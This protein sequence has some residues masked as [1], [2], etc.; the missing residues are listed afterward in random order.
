M[1]YDLL[2]ILH[3]FSAALLLTSLVY[4]FWLWRKAQDS[5]LVIGVIQKQTWA[6]ILPAAIF[7]LATGFTIIS[8]KHYELSA[9]WIRGSVLGFIIVMGSWIGFIY[10]LFARQEV[11]NKKF[12]DLLQKLL[13]FTC[14]IALLSMIFL[15]ANK[16]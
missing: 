12:Y 7:Q 2:K 5:S 3:I 1:L 16:I 14:G 10:F 11:E 6:V 15:M 4:S 9:L 8:L 13:L